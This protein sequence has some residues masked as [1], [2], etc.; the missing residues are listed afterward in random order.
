[1]FYIEFCLTCKI[2]KNKQTN[3]QTK[4]TVQY[5]VRFVICLW[6]TNSLSSYD[7]VS[8][9]WEV[10]WHSERAGLQQSHERLRDAA[11]G[12]AQRA[13]WR[14]HP[15]R[16]VAVPLHVWCNSGASLVAK[17]GTNILFQKTPEITLKKKHFWIQKYVQICHGFPFLKWC[18]T[19]QSV[20][21]FGC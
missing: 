1:M 5:T 6:G 2:N 19:S 17:F 13:S 7:G 12:L 4:S 10:A 3:K 18:D 11:K 14:G 8:E 9:P 15:N 16:C 20:H 21:Q